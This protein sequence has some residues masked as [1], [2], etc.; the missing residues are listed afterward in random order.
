MRLLYSAMCCD[1]LPAMLAVRLEHGGFCNSMPTWG[2]KWCLHHPLASQAVLCLAALCLAVVRGMHACSL[3]KPLDRVCLD[4]IVKR[5][6]ACQAPPTLLESHALRRL[7]HL[8]LTRQPR[9]QQALV[10]T[11]CFARILCCL[12]GGKCWWICGSVPSM[13]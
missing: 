1:V 11:D 9:A 6:E 3:S 4:A 13:P 8:H 12:R 7:Q 2:G 10:F 5:A